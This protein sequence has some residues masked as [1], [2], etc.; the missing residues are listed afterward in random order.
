MTPDDAIAQLRHVGFLGHVGDIELER[1]GDCWLGRLRREQAVAWFPTSDA[2]MRAL[3]RERRVLELVAEHCSFDVPRSLIAHDDTGVEVRTC[4]DGLV[5][6]SVVFDRLRAD[7]D[8]AVQFGTRVGA[9]LAELHVSVPINTCSDWLPHRLEWPMPLAPTLAAIQTVTP[10]ARLIQRAQEVLSSFEQLQVSSDDVVLVHG[11]LGFHNLALDPDSLHIRGVFDF[12]DAAVADR[13]LDFRY[14]F[15]DLGRF[16]LVEAAADEY[17][18]R[19]GRVIDLTRALLYNAV[20]AISF[21]A[22]HAGTEP[23][24]VSCGRTLNQDICWTRNAIAAALR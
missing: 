7:S 13:H 10:D 24:G 3:R 17:E 9:V 1:R 18:R 20:W 5:D 8:L 14:L 21:L 2:G 15:F 11:D 12:K 23:D 19:T 16:D 22:F 4:V 6:H